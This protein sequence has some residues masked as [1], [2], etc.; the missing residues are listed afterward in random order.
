MLIDVHFI[1]FSYAIN[2]QALCSSV[3]RIVG[4]RVKVFGLDGRHKVRWGVLTACVALSSYIVANAI[5]FFKDLVALCGAAVSDIL[6]CF[7]F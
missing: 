7:A 4:H 1:A 3:D 6:Q 5:P 2:S